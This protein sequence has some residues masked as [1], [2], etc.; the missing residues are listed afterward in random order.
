M[1]KDAFS[2]EAQVMLQLDLEMVF[3]YTS[4]IISESTT[5]YCLSPSIYVTGSR[6]TGHGEE[7]MKM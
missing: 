3:L 1:V 5:L 6:E 4:V 2:R 7:K